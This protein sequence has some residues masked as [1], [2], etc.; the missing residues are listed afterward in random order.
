MTKYYRS[1][2][3]LCTILSSLRGTKQSQGRV[4][5]IFPVIVV[6]SPSCCTTKNPIPLF[7]WL[8]PQLKCTKSL[9]K[10]MCRN[11]VPFV[12]PERVCSCSYLKQGLSYEVPKRSEWERGAAPL[13]N[14]LLTSVKMYFPWEEIKRWGVVVLN[15][16][17]NKL[18]YLRD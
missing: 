8:R 6:R 16:K 5:A 9:T 1:E 18:A 13:I 12:H 3:D 4:A 15:Y 14:L 11:P 7:L 2:A 17:R 10:Q